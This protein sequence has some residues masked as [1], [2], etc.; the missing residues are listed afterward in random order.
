MTQANPPRAP[1]DILDP[2]NR[3][4]DGDGGDADPVIRAM[5][6]I[7][8]AASEQEP[9]WRKFKTLMPE[10]SFIRV[11]RSGQEPDIYTMTHDRD[12]ESKSFLNI[13][14]QHENPANAKVSIMKGI[15]TS[16]PHFIFD[17]DEN[18]IEEFSATFVEANT[19]DKMTAIVERWGVRRSSPEFWPVL[20]SV[21]EF[22]ER[23]TPR[24]AGILDIN[25]Y[26]NL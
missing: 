6:T 25:R 14:M 8:F 15:Y 2:I 9:T 26:K 21:T 10:V 12:F 17:V 1:A 22:M 5:R 19:Q 16:Y 7:V 23:T 3:P 13:V 20:N 24:R 18:E 4:V 11:N